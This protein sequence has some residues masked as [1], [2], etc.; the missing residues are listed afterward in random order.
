M[1][2]REQTGVI[3]SGFVY[4]SWYPGSARDLVGS[5]KGERATRSMISASP[6]AA[7]FS[8]GSGVASPSQG[9]F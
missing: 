7:T 6:G 2:L 9:S 5:A 8:V 1:R 4:I 3:E